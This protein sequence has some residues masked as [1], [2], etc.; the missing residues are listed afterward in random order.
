MLSEGDD[1]EGSPD[2]AEEPGGASSLSDLRAGYRVLQVRSAPV[3]AGVVALGVLHLV[4]PLTPIT[5][6]AGVV[7]VPLLLLVHAIALRLLL[8][9]PSRRA[10]RD[11]RSRR[12]VTRWS[13]R[14]F[15][16]AVAPPAYGTLLAP[17]LGPVVAP[18]SYYAVN[19]AIF[20]YLRWHHARHERG[21][22]IHPVEK[23]A[24]ALVAL[25]ALAG[26]ALALALAAAAGFFVEWVSS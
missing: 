9:N 17:G 21:D 24:L 13:C 4:P 18:A 12:I 5:A 6:A 16:V 7:A 25:L 1:R 3:V 11:S 20:R 14:F 15:F 2:A 22:G 19:W 8:V 23:V 10:F 26:L